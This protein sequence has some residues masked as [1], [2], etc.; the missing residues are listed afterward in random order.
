[1]S[2]LASAK[3]TAPG[4]VSAMALGEPVQEHTFF[5]VSFANLTLP[6]FL[7]LVDARVADRTPAF[8]VT[9]NVDHI[10]RIQQDDAF[11]AA[12]G[13]AWLRVVDSTI[14]V[15]ASRLLRAPLR[16]K[17]SGSDLIYLLSEHAARK[18]HRVFYFG[19]APGVAEAAAQA[20]AQRYPGL[21]VAGTHCPPMDFEKEHETHQ[22]ALDAVNAAQ[23]DILFVAMGCPRQEIWLAEVFE[24]LGVPVAIGIGASLDFAS[25]RVKR[26]PVWM[27]KSGLEWFW[28]LCLEPRRMWRRYLVQD[29][30][31]AAILIRELLRKRRRA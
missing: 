28:R 15:W 31:F 3:S 4:T 2:S 21:E 6:E 26:A 11:R 16:E 14:L 19:A 8:V 9:P 7:E 24:Q 1:M 12:Y 30:A 10:C 18:S 22:A 17:L 13:R 20:L 29:A 23:P 5:G 27:Q 25:G